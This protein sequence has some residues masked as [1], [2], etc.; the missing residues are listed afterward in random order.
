MVLLEM[1][2]QV[3]IVGASVGQIVAD[4]RL[5]GKAGVNGRTQ[6]DVVGDVF[7]L[8]VLENGT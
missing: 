2:L 3:L 8:V 1:W 7:E 6:D 5:E 4:R